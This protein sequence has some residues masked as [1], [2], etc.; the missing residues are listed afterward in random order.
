MKLISLLPFVAA[1][2]Q[3][4]LPTEQ[5]LQDVA[6]EKDH[7]NVGWYDKVISEKNRILSDAKSSF[8]QYYEEL[9]EKA[10]EAW[11]GAAHSSGNAVDY[12]F[13]K[14]NEFADSVSDN[15]FD[16]AS[17]MESVRKMMGKRVT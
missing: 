6:V 11:S 13:E 9:Q 7:R 16:A 17:G 15:V 12:A 1:S 2:T 5:V 3:F 8:D 4:I 14:A 10:E